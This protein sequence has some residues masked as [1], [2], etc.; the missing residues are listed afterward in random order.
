M[1]RADQT[2]IGR[3][4]AL[5][6]GALLGAG[7]L[8]G[9]LAAPTEAVA[10]PAGGAGVAEAKHHRAPHH[11]C[12]FPAM[13]ASVLRFF[14]ASRRADAD[15]WAAAFAEGGVLSDPVGRPPI[16]GR[17]AIRAR[18]AS[19]LANFRPFLGI[20]PL[21]AHA[22]ADFVAVSWRGAAVTLSDRPVNWS[23]INVFRLDSQGLIKECSAYFEYAVFRAQLDPK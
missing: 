4:E 1:S 18:M 9:T 7:A 19:I 21:E 8:T 10:A 23:G 17:A 3:R 22:A 11:Y 15:A 12:G 13:P 20:T 16:T 2:L 14:D 6:F 5:G